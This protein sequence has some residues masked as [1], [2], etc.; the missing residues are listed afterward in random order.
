M[1]GGTKGTRE[2]KEDQIA[3]DRLR[4]KQEMNER[5][6]K[7]KSS[8]L[9][10]GEREPCFFCRIKVESGKRKDIAFPVPSSCFELRD[11]TENPWA[12]RGEKSFPTFRMSF[13]T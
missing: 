3:G 6:K 7:L 4:T 13:L 11:N 9:G 2:K 12:G 10:R 5:P 8:Q 1:G